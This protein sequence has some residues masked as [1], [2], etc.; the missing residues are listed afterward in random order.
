[1]CCAYARMYKIVTLCNATQLVNFSFMSIV[2]FMFFLFVCFCFFLLFVFL[3]F[4]VHIIL[5]IIINVIYYRHLKGTPFKGRE[6]VQYRLFFLL[7]TSLSLCTS[8]DEHPHPLVYKG[9]RPLSVRVGQCW[10]TK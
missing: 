6:D 7:C 5:C 3:F 9:G 10:C 1:V 2:H 4:F 8:G